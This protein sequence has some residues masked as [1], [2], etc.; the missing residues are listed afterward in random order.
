VLSNAVIEM[1]IRQ[2]GCN[3]IWV[4]RLVLGGYSIQLF[5][6]WY[7]YGLCDIA[8]ADPYYQARGKLSHV[9]SAEI[10]GKQALISSKLGPYLPH[11]LSVHPNPHNLLSTFPLPLFSKETV[12]NSMTSPSTSK[13]P[14]SSG[15]GRVSALTSSLE[16]MEKHSLFA[17]GASRSHLS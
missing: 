11:T 17:L 10:G 5:I 9:N 8:K 4:D 13:N 12:Y 15:L 3:D 2:G 7:G 16:L 1:M 6:W 14:F